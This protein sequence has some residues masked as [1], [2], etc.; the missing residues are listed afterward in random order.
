MLIVENVEVD[1]RWAMCGCRRAHPRMFS[2]ILR[3][4]L[5]GRSRN[6]S[7][8]EHPQVISP[9]IPCLATIHGESPDR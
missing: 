3:W 2:E 1:R 9:G 5:H 6:L 7:L 8:L 4:Y